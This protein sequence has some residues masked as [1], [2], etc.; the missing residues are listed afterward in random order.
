[1]PMDDYLGKELNEMCNFSEVIEERGIERGKIASEISMIR[2]KLSKGYLP[3]DIADWMEV[4]I[5]YIDQIQFM[6][7]SNPEASDIDLARKYFYDYV[8]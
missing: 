5:G 8:L 7:Q 1:M 4:D 3:E 2:R 6:I